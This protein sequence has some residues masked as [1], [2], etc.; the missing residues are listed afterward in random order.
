MQRALDNKLPLATVLQLAQD[1]DC[2]ALGVVMMVKEQKGRRSYQLYAA[3]NRVYTRQIYTL[4]SVSEENLVLTTGI[5][6]APAVASLSRVMQNGRNDKEVPELMFIVSES[7]LNRPIAVRPMHALHIEP[8]QL[9]ALLHGY[10]LHDVETCLLPMH[11]VPYENVWDQ[12]NN[13]KFFTPSCFFSSLP[14]EEK[15][16]IATARRKRRSCMYLVIQCRDSALYPQTL[17]CLHANGL[18][19]VPMTTVHKERFNNSVQHCYGPFR[20]VPLKTQR[21]QI[22]ELRP[23]HFGTQMVQQLFEAMVSAG[24]REEVFLALRRAGTR[25]TPGTLLYDGMYI[26]R[27]KVIN[28]WPA[29]AV[30]VLASYAV[31]QRLGR[32]GLEL[33]AESDIGLNDADLIATVGEELSELI[34]SE[35]AGLKDVVHRMTEPMKSYCALLLEMCDLLAQSGGIQEEPTSAAAAPSSDEAVEEPASAPA[36]VQPRLQHLQA[37]LSVKK[38]QQI[39]A[40]NAPPKARDDHAQQLY[41]T[42]YWAALHK[43]D[44]TRPR[45]RHLYEQMIMYYALFGIF[46]MAINDYNIDTNKCKKRTIKCKWIVRPT[47]QSL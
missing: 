19:A 22:Q 26:C 43:H 4:N 34:Q 44:Q 12:G 40:Y 38:Q 6:P 42:Y 41:T 3:I 29:Y 10:Q 5:E 17:S 37:V 18:V 39:M 15:A 24:V 46:I 28:S 2:S 32:Q 27:R 1:K 30:A 35:A 31:L 9:L 14:K 16:A 21:F 20:E 45:P 25:F 23:A 47:W 7:G 13:G 11:D 8:T 36:A 33:T